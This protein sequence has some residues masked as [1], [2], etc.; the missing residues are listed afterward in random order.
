MSTAKES[1]IGA[2]IKKIAAEGVRRNTQ[3][4]VSASNPRRPVPQAQ[5]IAI[6]ESMA[7]K[8]YG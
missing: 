6:A 8:K 1:F 5:R 3:K 2:K 7:R 4:P